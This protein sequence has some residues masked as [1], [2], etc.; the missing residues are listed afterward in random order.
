[1]VTCSPGASSP[2]IDLDARIGRD[3]H[4]SVATTWPFTFTQPFSIHSSASRREQMPSSLIRL[5]KRG[6]SGFG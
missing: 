2:G 3:A 4:A 5:D 1:M 6:S